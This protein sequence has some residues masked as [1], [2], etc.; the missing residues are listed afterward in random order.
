[1][2]LLKLPRRHDRRLFLLLVF[3][4]MVGIIL[5][6]S[7]STAS[8]ATVQTAK[9][10]ML[11]PY[12]SPGWL[13]LREDVQPISVSANNTGTISQ[14]M[15][16]SGLTGPLD[17]AYHQ[18]NGWHPPTGW[19]WDQNNTFLYILF[20]DG[21]EKHPVELT[22]ITPLAASGT[23]TVTETTTQTV[24]VTSTVT[25]TVTVTSTITPTVTIVRTVITTVTTVRT[26]TIVCLP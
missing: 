1:M 5:F 17:A 10:V 12:D 15:S 22:V 23:V 13:V 26:C 4:I 14:V 6:A 3:P 16:L 24:T 19:F 20:V 18:V 2:N 8:Q 9:Y 21:G 11:G 7:S 25:N